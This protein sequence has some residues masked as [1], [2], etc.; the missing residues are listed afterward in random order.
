MFVALDNG[1]APYDGF[2]FLKHRAMY[3]FAFLFNVQS[4]RW[5][6]ARRP[7]GKVRQRTQRV[8]KKSATIMM[9]LQ[10]HYLSLLSAGHEPSG[11]NAGVL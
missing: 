1:A 9:S 7:G 5:S 8:V 3:A 4:V 2:T 10:S 6:Q 11:A